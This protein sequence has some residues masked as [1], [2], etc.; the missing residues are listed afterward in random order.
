M[1]NT[2]K[3][4]KKKTPR[5]SFP[6]PAPSGD[7]GEM[8]TDRGVIDITFLWFGTTIRVNPGAGELELMEFMV[9]ANKIDVGETTKDLAKSAEAMEAVFVFLKGQI[10]PDDWPL[11]FDIA[12]TRRQ[13][14]EDLM[15]VAMAIVNRVAN[16]PIGPSDGSGGGTP[17]TPEKSTDGSSWQESTRSSLTRMA[18][19]DVPPT[20]PDLAM[21]YVMAAEGR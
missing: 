6:S 11:F 1:G 3:A 12:K 4:A 7:L 14:T 19:M 20:R 21:A 16:F 17:P 5:A 9:M 8:G 2:K 18:L 15:R 13:T 10:H